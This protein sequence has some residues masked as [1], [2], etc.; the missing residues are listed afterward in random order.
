VANLTRT[1]VMAISR[2]ILIGALGA[3]LVFGPVI[4][5]GQDR[6]IGEGGGSRPL[7]P[8][9]DTIRTDGSTEYYSINK[10]RPQL[11]APR[12]VERRP[13]Q[14]AAAVNQQLQNAMQGVINLQRDASKARLQDAL[15][16]LETTEM[17]A[18]YEGAS[19]GKAGEHEAP[20]KQAKSMLEPTSLDDLDSAPQTGG[21]SGNSTAEIA[22]L[23]AENE[24]LGKQLGIALRKAQ[25]YRDGQA[26][27]EEISDE[28]KQNAK[29]AAAAAA[30]NIVKR[31]I[32]VAIDK[33]GDSPATGLSGKVIK[34]GY[35]AAKV[36]AEHLNNHIYDEPAASGAEITADVSKVAAAKHGAVG[37]LGGGDKSTG[38]R[39]AAPLN[40]V[41]SAARAIDAANDGRA[42]DGVLETGKAVDSATTTVGKRNSVLKHADKAKKA[43]DTAS[44]AK[45]IYDSVQ[46]H[47]EVDA[48]GDHYQRQFER[49]ATESDQLVSEINAQIERNSAEIDRLRGCG[50]GA[51][52]DPVNALRLP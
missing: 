48:R 44:D 36:G 8:A 28:G 35:D 20:A 3:W 10:G 37:T 23:N 33:M 34:Y 39:A 43:K 32:D 2:S 14:D 12:A 47:Q 21:C 9:E 29:I 50:T 18:P 38:S 49:K 27:Q 17:G 1:F 45:G 46:L 26:L 31:G 42:V 40:S 11:A 5:L 13:S 25:I 7:P 24:A 4:A 6:A 16:Q 15:D 22:R 41:A 19:R 51:K 52:Q 30:G